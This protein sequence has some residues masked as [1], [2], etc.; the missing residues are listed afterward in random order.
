MFDI[1]FDDKNILTH[2]GKWSFKGIFIPRYF[3]REVSLSKKEYILRENDVDMDFYYKLGAKEANQF[4]AKYLGPQFYKKL[5]AMSLKFWVEP[6]LPLA[7]AVSCGGLKGGRFDRILLEKLYRN[8]DL[9]CEV[10][11]DNLKNILPIVTYFENS[12]E[13]LRVRFGR[14]IWKWLASNSHYHNISIVTWLENT[15]SNIDNCLEKLLFLKGLKPTVVS[16][17][18]KNDSCRFIEQRA[19]TWASN[20]S[21]ISSKSDFMSKYHIFSDSELMS[22]QLQ[23]RFDGNWSLRRMTR[24]HERWTKILNNRNYT[25]IP[26]SWVNGFDFEFIDGLSGSVE[27]NILKDALAIAQE[28]CEMGHCVSSYINSS[29]LSDY[30]VISLKSKKSRSTYGYC[31]RTKSE[32]HFLA[33]NQEVKCKDLLDVADILTKHLKS[34][35]LCSTPEAENKPNNGFLICNTLP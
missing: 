3:L 14:S 2:V 18:L 24:E 30:I 7:K 33:F 12:P 21:K 15:N 32:Q 29:R 23:D 22:E 35:V 25:N 6:I 11:K 13:E 28:G 19:I 27:I 4:I 5:T 34:I 20:N 31:F 26:F 1:S 8:F 9:V 16:K 17:H 10:Y